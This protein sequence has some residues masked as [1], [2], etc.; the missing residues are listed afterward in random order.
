MDRHVLCDASSIY[1]TID[2]YRPQACIYIFECCQYAAREGTCNVLLAVYCT[3][4]NVWKRVTFSIKNVF[5]H[6][7]EM[8]IVTAKQESIQWKEH[9]ATVEM[10]AVLH[11]LSRHGFHRVRIHLMWNMR[12]QKAR[13][14][15]KSIDPL[16]PTFG[17]VY[18]PYPFSYYCS[19]N[20]HGGGHARFYKKDNDIHR[21]RL[22]IEENEEKD[23]VY[24]F[25][26]PLMPEDRRRV[27][28]QRT[29]CCGILVADR[30]LYVHSPYMKLWERFDIQDYGA[31]R[32]LACPEEPRCSSFLTYL[33]GKIYMLC[34]FQLGCTYEDAGTE[35]RIIKCA[36]FRL[37]QTP[38]CE[39]YEVE[40]DTW[41]YLPDF[42]G[43]STVSPEESCQC[44]GY[45]A[46][47]F[48]QN[49]V[50]A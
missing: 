25:C 50:S 5:P 26:L 28:D 39:V 19:F 20:V 33:D 3:R 36:T 13:V 4:E 31:Y 47:R 44:V 15:S 14:Y 30:Y 18:R 8:E 27:F 35:K 1:H 46:S 37:Q 10:M 42:L 11:G 49:D 34:G 40:K 22:F 21:C 9:K 2:T 16:R 32:Q 23:R 43:K 38:T 12:K 45:G 41:T 7:R 29:H 17:S 48:I 6:S 24:D